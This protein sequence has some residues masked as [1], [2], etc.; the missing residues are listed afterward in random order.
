MQFCEKRAIATG[1]VLRKA[2]AREEIFALVFFFFRVT[3]YAP[4]IPLA[5]LDAFNSHFSSCVPSLPRK[6]DSQG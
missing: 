3:L 2:A 4:A 5:H 6:G 1:F